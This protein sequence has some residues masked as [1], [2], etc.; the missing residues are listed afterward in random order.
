MDDTPPPVSVRCSDLNPRLQTGSGLSVRLEI[1]R[2]NRIIRDSRLDMAESEI[3]ALSSERLDR[4]I[5][6]KQ[7][8]IGQ[9]SACEEHGNLHRAKGRWPF[10]TE[11]ARVKL[12]HLPFILNDRPS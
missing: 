1:W 8:L 10:T 9:I 2:I 5:P 3:G 12:A 7:I 4:R 6:D 11:D